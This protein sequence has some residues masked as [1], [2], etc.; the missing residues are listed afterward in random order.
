VKPLRLSLVH[1]NVGYLSILQ[2]AN[3]IAKPNNERRS[4]AQAEIL[5]S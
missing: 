1:R 2:I 4:A 3:L 5:A